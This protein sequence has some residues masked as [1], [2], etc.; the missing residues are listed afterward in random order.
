MTSKAKTRSVEEKRA[1]AKA[2]HAQ[3]EEQIKGLA[4][5]DQW[6]RFLDFR[7]AFHGYSLN[8]FILIWSQH[9]TATTVAGYSHWQKLGRQVRTGA[10]S[11]KIFGYSTKKITEADE[12]TGD[13][14]TRVRAYFP[15]LSV[16]DIDQTDLI[17]GRTDDSTVTHALTGTDGAGIY[18]MVAHYLAGRGWTVERGDTGEAFGY[19][20]TD[21]SKT[22]RISDSAEPA[23]A[24]KTIIHEAAHVLLHADL[25]AGEYVAHR[26]AYEAEAESVAYVIAAMFGLDTSSY[27]VGY[28]AGWAH[29]DLDVIR[30]T[31]ANVLRAVDVLTEHL[32]AEQLVAA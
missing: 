27:S 5:S 8:N 24:A 10:K 7:A 28:V 18:D 16:F 23:Q 14:T 22:V 20:R 2:L 11:I 4:E 31:A 6:K 25:E 13:E 17:E 1:Q 26:G 21:G 29:G 32:G 19:T 15:I 12:T 30:S 9:P 3:L